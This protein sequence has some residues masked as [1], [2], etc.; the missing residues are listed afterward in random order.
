[1]TSLSESCKGPK[2]EE[3]DRVIAKYEE[4]VK[5]LDYKI[6]ELQASA[7]GEPKTEQTNFGTQV[8]EIALK[9]KQKYFDQ[10]E[11]W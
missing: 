6:I 10:I 7:S 1:M 8:S 5:A 11:C 4:T 2:K 9:I 3:L